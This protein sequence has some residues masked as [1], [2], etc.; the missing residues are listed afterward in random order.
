MSE[1]LKRLLEDLSADDV[2]EAIEVIGVLRSNIRELNKRVNL[3]G[4]NFLP[5]Q[6][7]L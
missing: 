6:L 4:S 2:D 3:T 1:D 5:K 7:F